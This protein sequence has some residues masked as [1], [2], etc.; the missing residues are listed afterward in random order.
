MGNN[1]IKTVTKNADD[2]AS[3]IL[4]G[5]KLA[6]KKMIKSKIDKNQSLVISHKG[7][8]IKVKAADFH[9]LE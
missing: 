2:F 1:K 5:L 8:I 4:K 9:R 7:K 6:H 3:K